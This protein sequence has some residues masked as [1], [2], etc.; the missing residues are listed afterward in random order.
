M[1]NRFFLSLWPATCTN[2]VVLLAKNFAFPLAA[3]DL[4]CKTTRTKHPM[5]RSKTVASSRPRGEAS[6]PSVSLKFLAEHLGLSP[7][8]V[9]LVINRSPAAK[10]IPQRTQERVRAAARELNYRPNFMARSPRAPRSFT[11][12][13]VLPEI[14][15]AYAGLGMSGIEHHLPQESYFYFLVSPRH[16]NDLIYK[17]P[18]L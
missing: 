11:I 3:A 10:S 14:N 12:G 2:I 6:A 17:Y 8:T 16:L 5:P 9:S 4:L 13:V 1:I 7:A 15:E 18:R